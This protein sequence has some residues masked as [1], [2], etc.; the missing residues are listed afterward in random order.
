MNWKIGNRAVIANP[1]NH[2]EMR[3]ELCT[4]IGDSWKEG[5]L[6]IE[7]DSCIEIWRA[8]PSELKPIPDNYD[9]LQLSKWSECPFK[10]KELVTV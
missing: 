10:P 6:R 3:G 1:I 8:L 9:G 4:I 2:K 7:I 5:W